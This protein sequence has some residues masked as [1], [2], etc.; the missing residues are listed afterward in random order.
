MSSQMAGFHSFSRAE[1]YATAY[2]KNINSSAIYFV[3]VV[4]YKVNFP[5]SKLMSPLSK[6]EYVYKRVSLSSLTSDVGSIALISYP[7]TSDII[8]ITV[9]LQ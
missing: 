6:P 5:A 2:I 4:R 7:R 1:C 9:I 3:Y 8:F